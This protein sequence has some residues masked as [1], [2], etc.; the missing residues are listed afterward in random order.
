MTFSVAGWARFGAAGRRPPCEQ[1][2]LGRDYR[3]TD[4]PSLNGVVP[5][6][7]ETTEMLE[8]GP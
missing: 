4:E 2:G 5:G 6:M 8:L 3:Q 1:G 7:F